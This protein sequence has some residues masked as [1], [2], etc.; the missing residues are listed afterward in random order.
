MVPAGAL[1]I[2]SS[3]GVLAKP[4]PLALP[5][6]DTRTAEVGAPVV[7]GPAV[8]VVACVAGSEVEDADD[9]LAR[10]VDEADDPVWVVVSGAVEVGSMAVVGE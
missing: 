10:C 3:M 5:A 6:V 4:A 1:A 7:A 8:E 9:E 2:A